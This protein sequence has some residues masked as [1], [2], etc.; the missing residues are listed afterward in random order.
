MK[1]ILVFFL[2]LFLLS[3]Q[4]FPQT[5]W[6]ASL[7]ETNMKSFAQPFANVYG[8]ALNSGGFNS[9]SVSDLWGFSLSFKGMYISIPDEQLTYNPS[10][11]AGY[12][13]KPTSTIF[14]EKKGEVFAGPNGYITTP[15]GTNIA[16]VPVVFPQLG[17]SVLGTELILRYIPDVTIGSIEKVGLF[18]IGIKHSISRYIPLIP[19]DVAVQILYNSFK[20]EYQ[21]VGKIDASNLAFNAHASKSFGI[22]TPYFGLQYESATMDL[23]YEVKP[24]PSSGDPEVA[25]GLKGKVSMD[26]EN[27]FRAIL[28]ASLK[29]GFLLLNA[30]MGLGSQTVF[31][32]GLS[33]EF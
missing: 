9:A 14:G 29:L 32:G 18:G 25:A 20:F 8:I 6:F 16:P 7:N 13:T 17:V 5:A 24:E 28:G 22:V 3:N 30:D 33:F 10:L 4:S 26:G 21:D 12:T 1:K 11:P 2:F 19:V 31:G 27:S 23:E 15:P